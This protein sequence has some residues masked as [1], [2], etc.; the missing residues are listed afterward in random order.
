MV[1]FAESG[2]FVTEVT[3]RVRGLGYGGRP[4]GTHVEWLD[5]EAVRILPVTTA[6]YVLPLVE[7][8]EESPEPGA[9]KTPVGADLAPLLK[10][11]LS[12]VKNGV[13]VL[14]GMGLL[15]IILKGRG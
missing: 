12:W 9:P 7:K 2:R 8:V 6:S 13:W 5:N 14:F 1:R 15:V 10:D 11:I 3:F 4:D